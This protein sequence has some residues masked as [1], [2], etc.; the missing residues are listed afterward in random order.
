MLIYIAAHS[1][2]WWRGIAGSAGLLRVIA[3]IIPLFAIGA[4]QGAEGVIGMLKVPRPFTHL[5]I[6]LATV[7]I[8]LYTFRPHEYRPQR[9]PLVNALEKATDYVA[10][11]GTEKNQVFVTSPKAI[12]MLNLDPFSG[13]KNPE[14]H[15]LQDKKHPENELP[16]GS[17][18][19]WDSDFG[20][21]TDVQ[22]ESFSD[23][24]QFRTLLRL[25]SNDAAKPG[26]K[27][28][29]KVVVIQRN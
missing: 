18:A 10:G 23:S 3:G 14:L 17:V 29:Y 19:I 2:F 15:G 22:I 28:Y 11:K 13:R 9:T 12:V 21:L 24:T 7:C 4:L 6:L 26:D 1:Y 25:E 20:K 8:C 27:K 16:S 5:F